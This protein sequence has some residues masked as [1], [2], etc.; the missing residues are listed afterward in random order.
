MPNMGFQRKVALVLQR[1]YG[2]RVSKE[3][4]STGVC[5]SWAV[6]VMLLWVPPS[7]RGG[8]VVTE[9]GSTGPTWALHAL[10]P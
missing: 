6:H 3:V 9:E 8:K 1:L 2:C 5:L 10:P 4:N 7:L